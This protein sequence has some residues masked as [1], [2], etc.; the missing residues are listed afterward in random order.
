[1][2][3]KFKIENEEQLVSSLK[4]VIK[5]IKT[6]ENPDELNKYR[7]IFKKSVP[8]TMRSY[9]AAYLIKHAGKMGFHGQGNRRNSRG[10]NSSDSFR[11]STAQRPTR[12]KIVLPEDVSTSLFIGIGRKRGVFPKDIITLLIQGA[13]ID[14]ENIGDIRIL[15][16]YCFVQVLAEEADTIIEKLNNSYYRG[17]NLTVSHSRKQ[18]SESKQS[19]ETGDDRTEAD[20]DSLGNQ[21]DE[22]QATTNIAESESSLS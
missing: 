2:S 12:P 8:L 17:K 15:D 11:Q 9:V 14:R 4:D 3:E 21:A 19:S 20:S 18:D 6:E 1:M 5:A 13:N 22:N 7:S 10:K 16:N